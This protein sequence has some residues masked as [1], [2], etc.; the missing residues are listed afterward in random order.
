MTADGK[1]KLLDYV[2]DK[3]DDGFIY[4]TKRELKKIKPEMIEDYTSINI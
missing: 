1:L 4:A 2:E 3:K